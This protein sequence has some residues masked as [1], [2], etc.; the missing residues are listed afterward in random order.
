MNKSL[1]RLFV[2]IFVLIPVS[3]CAQ[4][5]EKGTEEVEKDLKADK[6]KTGWNFGALPVISF[7][8]DLGLQLGALTNLYHYGDGSRYPLYDH[9]LYL[10]ASWFLKGSGIFRFYYDSDR[11]IHGIRTSLDVSYIPDRTF[12]FFGF[13]GYEAVYNQSWED[14]AGPD[15]KSRVF[16]RL[17]RKFMRVKLDFQGKISSKK[18][19]W[20]AGADWYSISTSPVDVAHLNKGKS[21]D[22]LLPDSVDGLYQK[23]VDW[24]IIPQSEKDGGMFTVIKLGLV[25]DSRDNEPNPQRGVWT[26]LIVASAP[27]S[28]SNMNQGFMKLAITHR[29]YFTLVKEKLTFAYRL[30]MQANIAGHTPYYAQGIMYYSRMAGAYNEGLGGAKTLRGIQRNRVIG[31]G[32]VFGNFEFRWKFV[33]FY[34]LKQNFYFALSG[35]FDSG[36][37]IQFMDVEKQAKL[38]NDG[39]SPEDPGFVNLADYFSFG[40]EGFHNSLGAGLHIAM[41]QNFILAIDYGRALNEQDGKSGF[42]VGLNFLF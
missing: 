18:F 3:V 8:S 33:K 13:N 36:R 34:W 1:L 4:G 20:L 37:I 28:F 6:I 27:K 30:G 17:N 29:Q 41:N 22:K 5:D 11:L 12:K 19:L 31:D 42:Y 23:Y 7:D 38:I 32:M 40:T 26:E 9:S 25:F 14:D 16:Y 10:E 24:N 21:D 35:F 39:L 15:Y 2:F